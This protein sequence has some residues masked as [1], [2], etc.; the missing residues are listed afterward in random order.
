ML[1]KFNLLLLFAFYQLCSGHSYFSL[2][3]P[4]SI[5]LGEDYVAYL[6]YQNYFTDTTLRITLEG[7]TGTEDET[8]ITLKAGNTVNNEKVIFPVSS[9]NDALANQFP[10]TNFRQIVV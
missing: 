6:S 7:E 2:V 5:Q 9:V 3:G 10:Y 4:R 8:E 1:V